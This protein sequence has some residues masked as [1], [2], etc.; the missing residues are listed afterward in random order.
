MSVD[1]AEHEAGH[2]A[3]T[4]DRGRNVGHRE[5]KLG[6]GLTGRDL[7]VSVAAHVG[8]GADEDGLTIFSPLRGRPG[9]MRPGPG[10]CMHGPADRRM[11][12]SDSRRMRRLNNIEEV[13]QAVDLV[14]VVDHD[15]G[16]PLLQGESQLGL[17]LGVAVH[18]DA[19]GR[20][21]RVQGQMQLA[22]GGHVAPEG[23]FGKQRQH[24][25]AGKR[26][27]GEYH[28]EVLLASVPTRLRESSAASPQ[29][30]LGHHIGRRAELAGQLDRVAPAHLDVTAL[31]EAAPQGEHVRK[32][33]PSGHVEIMAL[34]LGRNFARM[35][36]SHRGAVQTS[37]ST[38]LSLRFEFR[39][40]VAVYCAKGC[41][42]RRCFLLNGVLHAVDARARGAPSLETP[43]PGRV[44]P[45]LPR[46][47][48]Q[49]GR[50]QS[51]SARCSPAAAPSGPTRTS[52]LR[53]NEL[54]RAGAPSR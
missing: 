37:A 13:P 14:E 10:P 11:R 54:H 32:A 38:L 42:A 20:K 49:A 35:P 39:C 7:L 36:P 3:H 5:P 45:P 29:V 48:G 27:G 1:A 43:P 12:R 16:D 52:L 15:Q 17:G 47:H 21:A 18:Q 31:V 34:H 4:R 24:R 9:R 8:G 50:R 22:A 6:V 40:V 33:R 44:Q 26:L 25:G 41:P 28:A 2:C 53:R 19:L 46:H 30:I 23:L 51:S